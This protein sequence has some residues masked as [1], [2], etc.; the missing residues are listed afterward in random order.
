MPE[1]RWRIALRHKWEVDENTF[2]AGE[3]HKLSDQN[4]IKDFFYK[5]EYEPENQFSTY[6]TLSGA[7]ENYTLTYLYQKKINDFFEVIERLPEA[8]L[9]IRKLKLFN[10][11][12]LYYE[13]QSNF[14]KFNKN[15]AKDIGRAGATPSDNYNVT[16]LDTNNVLSYPFQLFGF[17]NLNPSVGTRETFYSKD[18]NRNDN[19]TRYVFTT[20][21]DFYTKFYKIYDIQTDLL[22]LNIHNIRHIITPS[23]KYGYTREPNLKPEELYQF[24]GIDGIEHGNSAELSLEHK[25]QTKRGAEEGARILFGDD[26]LTGLRAHL[27][28]EFGIGIALDKAL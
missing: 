21:V 9:S 6:L 5:E 2:M 4:F 18:A 10:H 11:L 13:N 24:D 25:L 8:R 28:A 22:D 7:R 27:G 19:V 1:K 15:H 20:G 14:A 17:L 16:R 26:D 3:F 23:V 12:N